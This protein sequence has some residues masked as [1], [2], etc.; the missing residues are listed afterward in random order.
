MLFGGGLRV[1]T[2]EEQKNQL[3]RME[4]E[5]SEYYRDMLDLEFREI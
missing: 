3:L 2:P 1:N 4:R 5:D